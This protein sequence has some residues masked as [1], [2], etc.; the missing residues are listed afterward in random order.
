MLQGRGL[1]QAGLILGYI[2][3]GLALLM[4]VVLVIILVA[5][6]GAAIFAPN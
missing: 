3:L 5:G 2:A 4:L 1:A 6:A